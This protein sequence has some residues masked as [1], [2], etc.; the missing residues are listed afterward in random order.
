MLTIYRR[1]LKSCEHRKKGREYRRCK[2]P[3]WVDGL[4]GTLEIRRSLRM[5]DG[6]KAWALIREWET[7]DSIDQPSK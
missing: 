5:R 1:H 3:I 7:K 2:C 6:D 4:I